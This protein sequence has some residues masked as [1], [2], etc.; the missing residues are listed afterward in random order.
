MLDGA[1]IFTQN[2]E[3]GMLI[4]PLRLAPDTDVGAIYV[5]IVDSVSP[6]SGHWYK[7]SAKV[8]APKCIPVPWSP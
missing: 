8:N 7:E 3:H 1:A 5:L 4:G 2:F 6:D